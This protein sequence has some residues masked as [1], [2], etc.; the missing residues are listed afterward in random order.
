MNE[1]SITQQ[2]PSSALT[3][4]EL[5]HVVGGSGDPI[6]PVGNDDGPIDPELKATPILF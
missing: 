4:D 5:S 6:D 2:V 3:E 1:Q